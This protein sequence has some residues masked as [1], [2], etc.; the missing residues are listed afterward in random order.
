VNTYSKVSAHPPVPGFVTIR[1]PSLTRFADVVRACEGLAERRGPVVM[2]RRD[3]DLLSLVHLEV[4]NRLEADCQAGYRR[5]DAS[6]DVYRPTLKGAYR[7]HWVMLPP[8][9]GLLDR[10]DRERERV[11]LT[12]LGITPSG[13]D[14]PVRVSIVKEYREQAPA[15]ALFIVLALFGPELPTLILAILR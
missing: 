7:L 5:Y 3:L 6:N 9:T 1:L 13:V 15:I 2:G 10:R 14:R 11:L 12:E 8:L 4:K